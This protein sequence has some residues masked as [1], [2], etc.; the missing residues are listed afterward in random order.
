VQGLPNRDALRETRATTQQLE[1]HWKGYSGSLLCIITTHDGTL[2][3]IATTLLGQEIFHLSY[4]GAVPRLL[5]HSTTLPRH[6]RA[7]YLL[8]DLLWAQWPVAALASGLS[9]D[10]LTLHDVGNIREIRDARNQVS[11]RITRDNQGGFHIENPR[12]GYVLDL[13][14][15]HEESSHEENVSGVAP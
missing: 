14:P 5:D 13:S 2:D 4:D 12:F 6:F 10:D 9:K 7:D 3:F 8:R 1:A 15:V 11:L